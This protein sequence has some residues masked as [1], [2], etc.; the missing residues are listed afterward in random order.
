MYFGIQAFVKAE[1][2]DLIV[3]CFDSGGCVDLFEFGD[4]GSRATLTENEGIIIIVLEPAGA[5]R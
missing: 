1:V 3:Y 4:E 5:F 2:M